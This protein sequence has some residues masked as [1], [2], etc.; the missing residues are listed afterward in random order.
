MAPAREERD[1]WAEVSWEHGESKDLAKGEDVGAR[2]KELMMLGGWRRL[3]GKRSVGGQQRKKPGEARRT[4]GTRSGRS[5]GARETG[6]RRGRV[7]GR[8][9]PLPKGTGSRGRAG[10]RGLW[11]EEGRRRAVQGQGW[12]IRVKRRKNRARPWNPRLLGSGPGREGWRAGSGGA[13]PAQESKEPRRSGRRGSEG[14][15][16]PT[17]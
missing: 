6:Q 15:G 2:K 3:G 4:K 5:C 14:G 11:T 13:G 12:R 16:R 7:E 17:K 1:N 10:P 9:G 8:G